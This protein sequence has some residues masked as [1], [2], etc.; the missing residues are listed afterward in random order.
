MSHLRRRHIGQIDYILI[1]IVDKIDMNLSFLIVKVMD[2]VS[3]LIAV[4]IIIIILIVG[5]WTM[6]DHRR[7]VKGIWA[8]TSEFCNESEISNLLLYVKDNYEGRLVIL[9]DDKVITDQ[10]IRIK[11]LDTLRKQL[12]Q[13]FTIDVDILFS[14]K[15][16]LMPSNI[17]L[18]LDDNRMIL[19]KNN[20]KYADLY[21]LSS[22]NT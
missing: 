22:N 21:K 8:G 9:Q 19:I 10:E 17:T 6:Y 7:F 4:V 2:T 12:S 1:K 13:P 20:I 5:Y 14:N 18:T 3:L 15:D 16:K 11:G